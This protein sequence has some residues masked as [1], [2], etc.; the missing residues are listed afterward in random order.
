MKKTIALVGAILA[1]GL[2]AT[3]FGAYSVTTDMTVASEYVFRG[4]ELGDL[5][6]HPSVEISSQGGYLGIWEANQIQNSSVWNNETDVYGG[7]NY[8]LSDNLKL[9]VGA[10]YYNYEHHNMF[11]PKNTIEGYVGLNAENHG[12]TTG[13]YLYRDFR[14]NTYTS[15]GSVSYS[16]PLASIGASLDLTGKLGYVDA[17]SGD[18]DSYSYYGIDAVIPYKLK[19]N[20]TVSVGAHY[21]DAI[22]L[23][24]RST[25]TG[26]GGRKNLYWTASLTIGF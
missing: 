8:K 2:G 6:L 21:T 9:D 24:A 23:A 7:Y 1:S 11:F 15:Q 3:A 26:L 16:F 18:G 22:N 20:A 5:T 25:I 17:R 10:T 12:V 4:Q 14:L 19:E 13:V